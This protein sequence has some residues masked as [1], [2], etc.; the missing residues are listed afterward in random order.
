MVRLGFV[1]ILLAA[2]GQLLPLAAADSSNQF[3][4]P[5]PND[6]DHTHI[7]GTFAEG[8][9]IKLV[10]ETTWQTLA[11]VLWQDGTPQF[12]Y[13]PNSAPIVGTTFEWTVDLTG[14]DGNPNFNLSDGHTFFFGIFNSGTT[15]VFESQYINITSNAVT[16]SSTTTT[17]SPTQTSTHTTSSSTTPATTNTNTAAPTS[18]A[19]SKGAQAGIGVGVAIVGVALVIGAIVFFLARRRRAANIPPLPPSELPP[20]EIAKT[21]YG[22]P[23]ELPPTIPKYAARP[24]VE[25]PEQPPS[26][27]VPGIHEL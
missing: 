16:T 18:K 2:Q 13:L 26:P 27:R 5:S 22:P 11:L 10:W 3:I 4:S 15:D 20:T 25:L 23:A 19:L 12:Q 8:S 17:T 21:Y 7:E 1:A 24:P 9:L 6:G 14:Q